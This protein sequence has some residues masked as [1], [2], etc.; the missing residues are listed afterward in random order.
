MPVETENDSLCIFLLHFGVQPIFHVAPEVWPYLTFNILRVFLATVEN[1]RSLHLQ[2][3]KV[4]MVNPDTSSTVV[5][6]GSF[7]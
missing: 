5:K 2:S 3:F 7:I 6:V 1:F 4:Q